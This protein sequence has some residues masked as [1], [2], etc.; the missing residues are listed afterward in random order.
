MTRLWRR[1]RYT[2]LAALVLLVLAVPAIKR[3]DDWVTVYLPAAHALR[4]GQ[5]IYDAVPSFTYPPAMVLVPVPFSFLPLRPACLA[6]F[7]VNALGIIV[8]WRL[9][10]R[11]SAAGILQ[12]EQ[13]FDWR[14]PVI[15]LLGLLVGFRFIT[16]SLDH[17][18]T[19]LVIGALVLA[20][21]TLLWRR[22][23]LPAAVC[24]GAA[25]GFKATAAIWLLY[26]LWR[27]RWA[28]AALFLAVALGLNFLPDLLYPAPGGGW[29]L[30][31]WLH[32][33]VLAKVGAAASTGKWFTAPVFNQSLAG[34]ARRL[35]VLG[36]YSDNARP[37]AVSET[38]LTTIVHAAD[39]ALLA[40][41]ALAFWRARRAAPE[42][43][44]SAARSTPDPILPFEA[45]A[46]L[47][48]MVLLSPASSKPHFVTVFLPALLL[49]RLALRQRDRFAAWCLCVAILTSLVSNYA[50]MSLGKHFHAGERLGD[51]A[52]WLGG[53][54]WCALALWAGCVWALARRRP[55]DL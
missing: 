9:S 34:T 22:Q 27:R 29:W 51:G 23:A 1:H 44:A 26:F 4:A 25:A 16:D 42:E 8:L 39:A 40:V 18:Q 55:I 49:G 28:A 33:R 53:V 35:L 2:L 47:M 19:D 14:A 45:G 6:W 7:L 50:L 43:P 52:E 5:N 15:L 10:W 31:Q 32:E 46:L 24:L 54:T 38:T 41:S 36:Y 37:G 12:G 17:Q 21:A 30:H 3:T 11:L 48:L 20:G 13:A